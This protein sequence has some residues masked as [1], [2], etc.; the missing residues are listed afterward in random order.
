MTSTL[1]DAVEHLMKVQAQ[2]REVEAQRKGKL[3]DLRDYLIN[4]NLLVTDSKGKRRFFS[5]K[6]N[7]TY[8]EEFF[9]RIWK[10]PSDG[11]LRTIIKDAV[12]RNGSVSD[13]IFGSSIFTA[14]SLRSAVENGIISQE[15]IKPLILEEPQEVQRVRISNTNG[16][17]VFSESDEEEATA[18]V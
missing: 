15:E 9:K 5:E 13:I 8:V 4:H 17:I 3:N 2:L 18:N 10:K 7:V 14:S 1:E 12:G 11:D 6:F 16:F